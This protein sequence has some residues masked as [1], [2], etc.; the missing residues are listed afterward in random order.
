MMLLAGPALVLQTIRHG[1]QSVVARMFTRQRGLVSFLV[2]GVYA[3]KS[4]KA[5]ILQAMNLVHVAFRNRENRDLQMPTDL[6]MH[7][8]Y[9]NVPFS[10][11]SVAQLVF[12][13]EVLIKTLRDLEPDD[14]LFDYVQGM[15]LALDEQTEVIADFHLR[16]LLDYSNFLGIRPQMNFS[17]EC[18]YFDPSAGE[19]I[20]FPR[21][22]TWPLDLSEQLAILMEIPFEELYLRKSN[23]Y[24]RQLLTDHLLGYYKCHFPSVGEFK[25]P[26]VLSAVF[27]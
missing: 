11:V 13:S 8:A 26:E 12:I 22:G 4:G 2:K 16:F 18:K 14:Q 17:D 15:L 24:Q 10:P 21:T 19:F 25:S 1:D 6:K 23:R 27:E 5:A 9:R 3:R 7:H 20:G